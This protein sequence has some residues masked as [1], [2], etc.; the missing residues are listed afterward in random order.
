MDMERLQLHEVVAMD[1]RITQVLQLEVMMTT[2]ETRTSGSRD[3]PALTR[4]L[5]EADKEKMTS[6][7]KA[8]AKQTDTT[9]VK[10]ATEQQVADDLDTTQRISPREATQTRHLAIKA[11]ETGAQTTKA[12]TLTQCRTSKTQCLQETD[13]HK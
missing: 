5:P 6:P 12:A 13:G 1:T 8:V 2:L 10:K 3:S 9:K 11:D 4:A 7:A